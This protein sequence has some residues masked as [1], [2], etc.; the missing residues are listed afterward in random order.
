MSRASRDVGLLCS[1]LD[2][3]I[4]ASNPAANF[5]VET[6]VCHEIRQSRQDVIINQK[7]TPSPRLLTAQTFAADG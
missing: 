2:Q 7:P 5:K 4:S 1:V 6:T 3:L